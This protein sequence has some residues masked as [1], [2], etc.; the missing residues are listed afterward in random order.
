[1]SN[2]QI[3]WNICAMHQTPKIGGVQHLQNW[4]KGIRNRCHYS[5]VHGK[6]ECRN[7]CVNGPGSLILKAHDWNHIS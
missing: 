1:V 3:A 6:N 2:E 4:L 5:F 7:V